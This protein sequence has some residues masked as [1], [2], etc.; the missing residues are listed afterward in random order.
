MKYTKE[1][2]IITLTE[3]DAEFMVNKVQDRVRNVVHGEKSQR[4][5]IMSKLIEVHENIQ[6]LQIHTV[7]HATT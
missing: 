4:E 6:E 1:G 7:S 3:D 5:E 2:P